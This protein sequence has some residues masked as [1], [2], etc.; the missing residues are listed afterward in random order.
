MYHP[1]DYEGPIL[2]SFREKAFF[3]KKKASLR[4]DSGEWSDKF[5]LDAAGSTGTVECKANNMTYEIGVHNTL[6]HNSLTKQVTF[7]PFFVMMN[8]APF[9][10]EVQEDKRPADKWTKIEANQCVPL[11][12]KD[13]S[14]MLRVRACDN[15]HVS[16]PFKFDE[17]QCTLLKMENQVIFNS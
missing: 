7:V 5:A 12:P 10:I 1:P 11:W 3:G 8:K 17:V 2:F 9:A 15:K 4:V 6:T 14:K 16:R 13:E